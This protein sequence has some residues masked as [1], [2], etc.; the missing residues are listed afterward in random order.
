MI[1]SGA[2]YSANGIQK[3]YNLDAYGTAVVYFAIRYT[4]YDLYSLY[5]DDFEGHPIYTPSGN[6]DKIYEKTRN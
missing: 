5:L 1:D 4:G 6:L 3:T 2:L